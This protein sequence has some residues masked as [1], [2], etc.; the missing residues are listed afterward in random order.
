MRLP[1]MLNYPDNL[2]S[3][4]RPIHEGPQRA[5]SDFSLVLPGCYSNLSTGVITCPLE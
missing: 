4:R 2:T 5:S 1:G 3:S